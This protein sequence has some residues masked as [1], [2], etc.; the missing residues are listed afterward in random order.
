MPPAGIREPGAPGAVEGE[1][2]AGGRDE[3]KTRIRMI[4][5]T[6]EGRTIP[7]IIRMIKQMQPAQ[8]HY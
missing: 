8:Q 6:I 5:K 2:V 4:I 7:M 1:V 3:E